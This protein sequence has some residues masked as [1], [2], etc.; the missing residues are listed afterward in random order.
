VVLGDL[1]DQSRRAVPS[2]EEILAQLRAAGWQEISNNKWN[3]HG[4][5][6]AVRFEW[7]TGYDPGLLLITTQWWL[8]CRGTPDDPDSAVY[9]FQGRTRHWQLVLETEADLD[10]RNMREESGLEY[11]L[12]PL[13][14]RARKCP[15]RAE[16]A[17][18]S[19]AT[20]H[21]GP[22]PLPNR[23]VVFVFQRDVISDF[24]HAAFRIQVEDDRFAVTQG[25]RRLLDNGA[26][27]LSN[28]RRSRVA[29]CSD[30]RH[31]H[32][33]RFLDQ[34][35]QSDW[36]EALRWTTD[37]RLLSPKLAYKIAHLAA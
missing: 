5:I 27:P 15:H 14:S 35:F 20:K 30:R 28:E 29:Y 37:R 24:F 8:L 16:E 33:G 17:T 22:G 31:C 26:L 1:N 9:I 18:V 13:D 11:K 4:E 10:P 3:A 36:Q 19:S 7:Q 2:E 6:V 21:Y 12:S 32:S 23:P 25:K 34:W